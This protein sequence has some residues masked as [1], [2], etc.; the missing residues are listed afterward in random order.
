MTIHNSIRTLTVAALL[1]MTVVSVSANFALAER[2]PD[3]NDPYT[4]CVIENRMTGELEFYATGT[5]YRN[6]VTGR[7]MV[8][9]PNGAWIG[10]SLPVFDPSVPVGGGVYAP[11]SGG[12]STPST[13][14]V[15][16]PK[17]GDGV[18]AQP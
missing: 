2:K 13:G 16:A 15:Y 14:G 11:A 1:A 12:L 9:G 4:M 18:F 10:R 8:C 17:A 5:I 6:P 3:P 7:S